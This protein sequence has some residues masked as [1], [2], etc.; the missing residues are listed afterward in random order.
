MYI[1]TI[2][3][4][5]YRFFMR[6]NYYFYYFIIILKTNKII[7]FIKKVIFNKTIGNSINNNAE[8]L[9]NLPINNI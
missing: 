6:L 8:N 7:S 4:Y 3:Y 1:I 2:L 5:N 9:Y